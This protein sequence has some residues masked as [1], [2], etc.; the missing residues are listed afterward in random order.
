MVEEGV[1]GAAGV[2]P[3]EQPRPDRVFWQLCEREVEQLDVVGGG[4]GARVARTQHTGERLLAGRLIAEQRMEAEAVLVVTGRLLLVGVGSHQ[5]RVEVEDHPLGRPRQLPD[6]RPRCRARAPD[7]R[8]PPRVEG[9]NRPPGSRI[10][11]EPRRTASAGR[12]AHAGRQGSHHRRRASPPG[13]AASD[14]DRGASGAYAH[15]P[16]PPRATASDPPDQRR[17]QAAPCP[18]ARSDRSASATTCSLSTDSARFTCMVILLGRDVRR[19]HPHRPCTGGHPRPQ[20]N[21]DRG[22]Y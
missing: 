13:H 22:N 6:P 4:V 17:Q 1:G 7:R 8:E 12:A 15:H 9:R 16:S 19:R 14:R 18:P 11:G 21:P 5:R 10:G 20:A 3:H 2:G